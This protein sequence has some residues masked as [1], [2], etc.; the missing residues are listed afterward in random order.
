MRALVGG[1]PGGKPL[2]EGLREEGMEVSWPFHPRAHLPHTCQ[3][4]PSGP[5]PEPAPSLA[6][7]VGDCPEDQPWFRLSRQRLQPLG[8]RNR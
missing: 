8:S 3:S 1:A 6:P 2:G 7:G 5:H 4:G